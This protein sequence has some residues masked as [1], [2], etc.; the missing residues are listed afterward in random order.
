MNV[1]VDA[2]LVIER[3]YSEHDQQMFAAISGDYNP[4]HMDFIE[5]RRL[6]FGEQVVHGIHHVLWALT[7]LVA[8]RKTPIQLHNLKA[9]FMKPMGLEKPVYL[10]VSQFTSHQFECKLHADK[11]GKG[12]ALCSIS[13]DYEEDQCEYSYLEEKDS[14]STFC[15]ALSIQQMES[16]TDQLTIGFNTEA[17]N[18]LYPEL[19]TK[20]NP[21]QLGFLLT[22]TRLVGM[23]CPGLNSIY[24][25]LHANFRSEK[26]ARKRELLTYKVVSINE[27]LN[28]MTMEA[29][30][31][32]ATA[33]IQCFIRPSKISQITMNMLQ[34]KIRKDE[35]SGQRALIIGG[36]R[37]LG[38]L[39]VK[40]IAAGGAQHIHLTYHSGREDALRVMD[41]VRDVCD[42]IQC[43]QYDV[44]ADEQASFDTA[45][46]KNITHCYYFASPKILSNNSPMMNKELLN[47]YLN[48]Y[49]YGLEKIVHHLLFYSNNKVKL[50]NPS[51]IFIDSLDANFTE[52]VIAK[53]SVEIYGSYLEKNNPSIQFIN[54]RFP[55]LKTDQ[56]VS[57]I[58]ELLEEPVDRLIDFLIS[59]KDEPHEN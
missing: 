37:G 26:P 25:G 54:V 5:A 12:S 32:H 9:R 46:F 40:I 47:Y 53:K 7:I 16:K 29:S 10:I 22:T 1:T 50:F 56:T 51:T 18:E 2:D 17:L 27:Q 57:I 8:K 33:T 44:L 30:G 14:F 58:P 31:T 24:I 36:S 13:M 23:E 42:S 21:Y 39:A 28:A 55:K 15:K 43:F 49:L 6:L 34:D 38:E 52:Y 48:V 20:I 4:I 59:S 11:H 3:K 41:E 19:L 45:L 35:F